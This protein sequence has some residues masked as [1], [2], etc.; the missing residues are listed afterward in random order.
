M[1]LRQ[2]DIDKSY[3]FA[4]LQSNNYGARGQSDPLKIIQDIYVGKLGEIVAGAY[5][6]SIGVKVYYPD[7]KIYEAT[8]K[9]WESDLKEMS[10]SRKFAVKSQEIR[11]ANQ[12]EVSWVFQK[13]DKKKV[14]YDKEIFDNASDD[15]YCMFVQIDLLNKTGEVKSVVKTS[16]LQEHNLFEEMKKE[17]LRSNKKAVYYNSLASIGNLWQI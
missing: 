6:Q 3:K 8:E 7:F 12:Y 2:Q 14:G 10:G 13:D 16:Y 1:K 11:M 5:L 4:T 17:S 9:S 15:H